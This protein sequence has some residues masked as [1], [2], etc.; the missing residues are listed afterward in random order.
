M[1]FH[2]CFHGFC[3]GGWQSHRH[4]KANEPCIIWRKNL[5]NLFP[6]IGVQ[7]W[8]FSSLWSCPLLGAGSLCGAEQSR[9]EQSYLAGGAV[10]QARPV[11][12]GQVEVGG[13]GTRVQLARGQQAQVAAATVVQRA[14]MSGHCGQNREVHQSLTLWGVCFLQEENC[15]PCTVVTMQCLKSKTHRSKLCLLPLSYSLLYA[16]MNHCH[17]CKFNE[18]MRGLKKSSIFNF[19]FNDERKD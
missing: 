3:P 19:F 7:P 1:F 5:A 16:K 9:A 8:A 15:V 13:A 2:G 17:G 6:T 12:R 14:H 10:G 11:V 4:L 18:R